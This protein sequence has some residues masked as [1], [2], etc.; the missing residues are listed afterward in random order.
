VRLGDRSW[1]AVKDHDEIS[2]VSLDQFL[3]AQGYCKPLADLCKL[4]AEERRISRSI[5]RICSR[6]L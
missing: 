4:L 1:R 3:R 5:S 2:P 6:L